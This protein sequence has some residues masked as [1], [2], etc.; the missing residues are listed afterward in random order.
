[1]LAVVGSVARPGRFW[2]GMADLQDAA[3]ISQGSAAL[4]HGSPQ[5]VHCRTFVIAVV[6]LVGYSMKFA[7]RP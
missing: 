7:K 6:Y 4:D 1:M 2:A 5:D 3:I